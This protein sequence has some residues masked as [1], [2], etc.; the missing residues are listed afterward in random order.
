MSEEA[1]IELTA[2]ERQLLG[3]R[4]QAPIA[5]W[6]LHRVR[7]RLEAARR[8]RNV[9]QAA[10]ADAIGVGEATLR[11]LEGKHTQ[12]VPLQ[13]LVNCALVLD[14]PLSALIDADDCRWSGPAVSPP[15]W[16]KLDRMLVSDP[17]VLPPA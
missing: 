4:Q 2:A 10:L 5:N 16:R 12:K 11:R 7:S 15:S 3:R 17:P 1:G 8:A 13:I 6:E 14:V 9:T